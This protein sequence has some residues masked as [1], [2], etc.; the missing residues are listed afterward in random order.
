[1]WLRRNFDTTPPP[2]RISFDKDGHA[3]ALT[4]LERSGRPAPAPTPM[5]AGVTANTPRVSVERFLKRLGLTA[6]QGYHALSL[7]TFPQ[8]HSGIPNS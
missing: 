7:E 1:M 2:C 8:G 5:Y 4:D 3:I 6:R